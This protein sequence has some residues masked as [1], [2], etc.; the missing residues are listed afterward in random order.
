LGAEKMTLYVNEAQLLYCIGCV[1]NLQIGQKIFLIYL[2]NDLEL[3]KR[4]KKLKI[5]VHLLIFFRL[6]AAASEIN[7][8][9]AVMILGELQAILTDTSMHSE[10]LFHALNIV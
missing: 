2:L 1:I 3:E 7:R 6:I 5:S 10:R 4:K 9:P 8:Q